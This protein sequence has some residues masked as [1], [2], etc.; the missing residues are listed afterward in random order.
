MNLRYTVLRLAAL[1]ARFLPFRVGYFFADWCGDIYFLL[2]A[3]RRRIIGQNI[4]RVM[5][6]DRNG[7]IPNGK[8]RQVFRNVAKNYFDL[9]KLSQ[10]GQGD[11]NSRTIIKGWQHLIR[12]A[13]DGKGVILA[14]AHLG[15]F[16]FGAQILALR[17]IEMTVLVEAFN[18]TPL[19]RN[20]ALLRQRK[21]VK[22]L[23]VNTS[24]LKGVL[25][26]LHRGETL[27]IVCDRDL[28]GNGVKIK[29][30]GEEAALPS[31]A[32]SLALRTGAA[33]V[34][35]FSLRTPGNNSCIYIEPQLKMIDRG[36]REQTIK[37]NLE[38]LAAVMEK[39]IRQYPEQWAVFGER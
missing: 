6:A 17:G 36:G 29:F 15:N 24:G 22:I 4:M 38:K 27:V 26:A 5:G 11:I 16:E 28:Q 13:N 31:G 21:G 12:A 14:T 9:T 33:I 19:L 30:L 32:V 2:S 7:I 34:P 10:M 3:K 1:A 39:Y 23:P 8:V 37:D 18:S 25:R 35:I 20:I